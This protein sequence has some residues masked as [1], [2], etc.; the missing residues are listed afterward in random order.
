MSDQ[1]LE[2][3]SGLYFKPIED[4][5]QNDRYSDI[6]IRGFESIYVKESGIVMPARG[7]KFESREKLET[8]VNILARGLGVPLDESNPIL[9]TRFS[10]GERINVVIPPVTLRP[11]V[12]IRKFIS[13]YFKEQR[14]I[15]VGMIDH[16]GIEMLKFF[17]KMKKRVII[18]G[19]PNSGKTTILNLLCKNI[20][21][22]QGTV[23]SVEDTR[24]IR[25]ESPLW[26]SLIPNPL[27]QGKSREEKFRQ[28]LMN[29]LR[30]DVDILIIGEIRGAEITEMI[31]AFNTGTGGMGT[32][33]AGSAESTLSRMEAL[34]KSHSTM[35]EEAIRQL[36]RENIDIIVHVKTL[37]D[38]RKRITD[39]LEVVKD[40]PNRFN[41]LYEFVPDKIEKWAFI[42]GKF[43]VKNRPEFLKERLFIS[44]AEIPG[45]W[46]EK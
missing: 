26:E 10:T 15:D 37:G 23:V 3:L 8:A 31:S 5:L 20:G 34:M 12:T 22:E 16:A 40:R 1:I 18:S 13:R 19:A 41:P 28:V 44:E 4:L 9:D 45:F 27:D 35:R 25:I 14:L 43:E 30:M 7:R 36:L 24:E 38:R 17:V 29:I 42:T 46:R 39:I 21:E 11:I 33:H 6:Y 32:I 2:L